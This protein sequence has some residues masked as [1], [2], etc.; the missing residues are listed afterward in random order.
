MFIR[1][2]LHFREV[3]YSDLVWLRDLRNAPDMDA[4]RRDPL[5]LQTLDQQDLW[6][7][8]L[9]RDNQAFII[10]TEANPL[11]RVGMLR[12]SHFDWLH[13]SVGITG[14]DIHPS[15]GGKGYGT[16]IMRGAIE[17]CLFT[18]GFHRV[19]GQALI[20]NKAAQ[21]IITKAGMVQEGVWRKYLR[22][23]GE[24]LDFLQYA[25]LEDEYQPDGSVPKGL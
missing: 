11:T 23:G 4:G 21:H 14:V 25:V 22:R 15:Q 5:S 10:C 1:Q 18:L 2:G 24:W 20:T 6:Y 12:L 3:E 7:K 9:N 13:R 19:T 16:R 8:S 17:Y